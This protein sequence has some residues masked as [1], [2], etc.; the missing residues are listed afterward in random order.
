VGSS[1][2]AFYQNYAEDGNFTDK[3]FT[4]NMGVPYA[5]FGQ[6]KNGGHCLLGLQK[7]DIYLYRDADHSGSTSFEF[8]YYGNE[9]GDITYNYANKVGV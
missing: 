5:D 4:Y 6:P 8:T 2:T 9:L 3:V 7:V 1:G